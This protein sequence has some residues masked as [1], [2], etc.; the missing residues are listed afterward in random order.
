MTSAQRVYS[1][2]EDACAVARRE[3]KS[4]SG[5]GYAIDRIVV[6]HALADLER[7]AARLEPV[8][9]ANEGFR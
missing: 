5:G 6:R 8:V 1:A 3:S 7:I 4:W 2:V 9:T